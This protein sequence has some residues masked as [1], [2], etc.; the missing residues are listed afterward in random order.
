[1]M[2]DSGSP[3]LTRPPNGP[4]KS[5]ITSGRVPTL[6]PMEAD[7]RLASVDGTA[8]TFPLPWKGVH[9]LAGEGLKSA[10]FPGTPPGKMTAVPPLLLVAR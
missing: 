5:A 8:L 1:M 6:L 10:D 3:L 7:I 4:V 2:F 9:G